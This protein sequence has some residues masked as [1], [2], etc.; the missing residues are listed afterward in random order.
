[1]S[2]ECNAPRTGTHEGK[3][4]T[5]EGGFAHT[6]LSNQCRHA[7]RTERMRE[8][9]DDH[10]FIIGVT[11]GYM[12]EDKL[13]NHRVSTSSIFEYGFSMQLIVFQ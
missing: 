5:D 6:C 9:F 3:H 7:T 10:T 8:A 11:I 2:V 1:M 13:R 4:Q 12:V